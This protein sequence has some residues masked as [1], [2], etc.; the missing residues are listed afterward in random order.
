MSVMRSHDREENKSAPLFWTGI[1][2][3]AA[4]QIS[5]TRSSDNPGDC[6]VFLCLKFGCVEKVSTSGTLD[7]FTFKLSKVSDLHIAFRK[8]RDQVKM[9]AHCLNVATQR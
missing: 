7:G 3:P 6:R 8:A 5:E 1:Q 9:T 2:I 4:H